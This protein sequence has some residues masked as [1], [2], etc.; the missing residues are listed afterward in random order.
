MQNLGLRNVIFFE[1][2]RFRYF[3]ISKWKDRVKENARN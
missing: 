3:D 1:I 2:R